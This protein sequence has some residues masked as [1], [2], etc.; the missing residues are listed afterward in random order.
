MGADLRVPLAPLLEAFGLPVTVTRPAPD[1]APIETEGAWIEQDAEVPPGTEFRRRE[2]RKVLLLDRSV[3]PTAPHGTRILAPEI[4]GGE[5]LAWL[6]DTLAA[7][8][9]DAFEVIVVRDLS[10][11]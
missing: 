3:V 1:D 5:V 4:D 6:V 8:D 11:S 7:A 10:E 9:R 2:T